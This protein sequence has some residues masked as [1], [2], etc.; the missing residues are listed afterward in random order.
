MAQLRLADMYDKGIGRK[1]D[2]I[3]ATYWYEKA[4]EKNIRRAQETISLMYQKGIGVP[5]NKKQA[6]Y[7]AD[8]AANWQGY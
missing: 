8:R 3:K 6:Q 4:A 7:W 1:K 5:K 2:K